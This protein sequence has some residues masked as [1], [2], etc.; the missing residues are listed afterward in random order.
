MK[1]TIVFSLICILSCSLIN[2]D[3]FFDKD[4]LYIDVDSFK[5]NTEGDEFYIHVGNNVWL[6]THTINRDAS[7]MFAYECN[8]SKSTV[9][10]GYK[11][12]YE[13]MWK[14]PYCYKYWPLGKPCGNPD[15][16]S[17]FK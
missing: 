6:V 13:K 17:K 12:E 10:P 4:K 16:P 3:S 15:C 1:K 9:I 8:L 2:A 7:G 5:A 14:C 11:S